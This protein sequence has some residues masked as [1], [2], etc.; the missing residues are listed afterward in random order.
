LP[1]SAASQRWLRILQLLGLFTLIYILL[2]PLGGYRT[3]RPLILR[4][5]SILPVILGLMYFYSASTY[6]LLQ[7]LSGP[8]RRWYIGGVVLFGA[9]FMNADKLKMTNNNQCER[10][11][12]LQLA[13]SSEPIV[14]LNTDCTVMAW[15]KITDPLQSDYNAQLLEFWG[16]TKGKKLYYQ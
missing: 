15:E 11:A 8:P 10:Q 1:P 4:R 16:V 6:Y 7:H 12:F 3:Y 2:L 14:H 5:D 9:I 13:Q